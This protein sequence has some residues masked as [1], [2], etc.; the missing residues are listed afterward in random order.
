[1]DDVGRCV[2]ALKALNLAGGVSWWK[3]TEEGSTQKEAMKTHKYHSPTTHM[4]VSSSSVYVP[5]MKSLF[6]LYAM[7]AALW[8]FKH[9]MLSICQSVSSHYAPLHA[10]SLCIIFKMRSE[11]ITRLNMQC[12]QGSQTELNTFSISYHICA[13]YFQTWV[14]YPNSI[15]N[16]N[17]FSL[18]KKDSAALFSKQRGKIWLQRCCR[19]LHHF[20]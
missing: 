5:Q 6:S 2:V 11:A 7:K 17:H 4:T 10:V 18:H 16:P 1:M 14:N 13:N 19:H 15:V 20:P 9:S 3:K 12:R 8:N